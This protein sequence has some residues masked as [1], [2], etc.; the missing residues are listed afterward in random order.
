M[1]PLSPLPLLAR[2][3]LCVRYYFILLVY[4]R[5]RALMS[6]QPVGISPVLYM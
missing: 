2:A 4:V 3:C 5:Q 1:K 6:Y